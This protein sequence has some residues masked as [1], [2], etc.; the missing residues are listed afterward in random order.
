MQPVAS[1]PI[2]QSGQSAAV[3]SGTGQTVRSG[4]RET[5]TLE[6]LAVVLSHFDIGIIDSVVEFP[7]GSRKAPKL[8]LV[9]EQG[10]FLMKRRARGKDDPFKVAFCHAI[11]LYLASKQFP[12]PHLIGTKKENNSML[13]WR[14]GVYELF[15]YIPGQG[16]PQTLESTFDSGRV[17]ALYHKLLENFKSEW[18]PPTGSYHI[19]PQVE[20]GLRQITQTLPVGMR[21]SAEQILPLLNFL[22]ESYSAAADAVERQGMDAWP[23][24]IVHADWHPGNMLFRDNHVV[25]VIDYDSAR[26]LPRI[27]DIAN[28]CLQFSILGGDT[29]VSQWP[30]YPDESRFKRFLRGYDEVMLLSQAEIATVPHLMIEALI[31]E[32]VFPIAATGQFGRMDGLAFLQMVSRKVKWLQK[33]AKMLV[34]L[35]EG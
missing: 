6:E 20:Q 9:S 10:K 32:A 33:N 28:G 29:D 3:V 24:Q 35:A 23:R 13:Q 11:Q 17:L 27:I 31:A 19:A 34:E 18:K 26:L 16:Y 30:D 1:S 21:A 4:Q 5:F 8:L 22:L 14:N 2:Q 7:R 12:L 25:A 15:E